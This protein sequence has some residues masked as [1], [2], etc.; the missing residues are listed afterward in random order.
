MTTGP[1]S[2]HEPVAFGLIV[3]GDEVLNGT[4]S[5][6]HL[7][8]FKTLLGGR[9]HALA[10][11]WVLPDDPEVLTDHLRWSMGRDVPVF[12]CGGIGA[13]PDDHTRACAAAAGGV[14]LVRDSRAAALL[15]ARFGAGAYPH[16]IL[17][18]D[19]PAGCG[20]IPNPINQ[21]PGFSL[22]AHWFLPGFP[23]MAW[24]M[25]EWVL[26]QHYGSAALVN[27]AAI[28]VIGVPESELIP[29]MC[30]LGERFPRLKMFSLPHLGDD[31][32]ILLG[33]RGRDDPG[34]AIEALCQRLREA[35]M[36]FRECRPGDCAGRDA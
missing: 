36:G 29:V 8:A 2:L 28:E 19:L 11:H 32:H 6:Q 7:S 1:R 30:D 9:G 13:T 17:M 27:E 23:Q 5:D 3:I 25:A 4:R 18:A 24:P 21:I 34:P 15:E 35:A 14:D 31:P 10:W 20:L 16:R 33:F 26:D 12:V 22:A